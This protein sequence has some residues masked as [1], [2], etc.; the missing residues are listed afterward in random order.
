M[1]RDLG[2]L[3]ESNEELWGCAEV[4]FTIDTRIED[5]EIIEREY[6]FSHAPEWDKWV[7]TEF[8]EKRA[9]NTSRVTDRTWRRT[10][11]VISHDLE[12]LTIDVPPE[13]EQE[14]EELLGLEDMT[15]QVPS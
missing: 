13:V 15:I 1:L 7:F 4:S 2:E 3:Q 14:L 8:E 12:A 6:T 11:H 10:R 5:G 9:E